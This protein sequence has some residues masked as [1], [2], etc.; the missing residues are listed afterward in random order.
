MNLAQIQAIIFDFGGVLINIDYDATIRAFQSLGVKN[1]ETLYSQASQSNLFNDLETGVITPESFI[2]RLQE[3]YLH[4]TSKEQIIDA[5]N[6]M[7]LEVPSVSIT[8]LQQLKKQGFSLYLL[9]NT[10]AIHIDKA[11]EEWKKTAKTGMD[12]FFDKVYLSH[13]MKMRKPHPEIFEFVCREEGLNPKSTLFID[14]SIQH[15][16]GARKVGL[17]TLHLTN[18]AMLATLFS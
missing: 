11:L 14:D 10:N 9:S 15:I 12:S 6:K 18:Q 8:L 4:E 5:W 13:E 2:H 1:F 16:E 17:Q 7:I 3:E